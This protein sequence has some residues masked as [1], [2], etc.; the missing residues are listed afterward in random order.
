MSGLIIVFKL[1]G[2]SLSYVEGGLA[3][4]AQ[5]R[6]KVD[7]PSPAACAAAAI[8]SYSSSVIMTG[9]RFV[10]AGLPRD[11][12]VGRDTIFSMC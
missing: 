9:T 3:L 6:R 10:R 7:T 2:M 12:F 11:S 8:R 1:V 4:R 5:M